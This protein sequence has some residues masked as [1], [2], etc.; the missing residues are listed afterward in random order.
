MALLLLPHIV[1]HIEKTLKPTVNV[2]LLGNQ[3]SHLT[4]QETVLEIVDHDLGMNYPAMVETC[5]GGWRHEGTINLYK[6]E[7]IDSLS[8]L[9]FDAG[10]L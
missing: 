7:F 1:P 5:G 4:H 10:G 8:N 6:P 9:G 2:W 3:N